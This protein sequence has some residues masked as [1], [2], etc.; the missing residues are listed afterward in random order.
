[1][2][3][4]FLTEWVEAEST[5]GWN[6]FDF[7]KAF[8]G[9][10]YRFSYACA[11]RFLPHGTA[12]WDEAAATGVDALIDASVKLATA[13]KGLSAPQSWSFIKQSIEWEIKKFVSRKR[14][15]ES[16]DAL[17]PDATTD[18]DKFDQ[19]WVRT[20]VALSQ[21]PSFLLE[22]IVDELSKL[23][24]RHQAA[25]ALRYF[26]EFP[27]ARVDELFEVHTATI[28]QLAVRTLTHLVGHHVASAPT[29]PFRPA[30]VKP[31][32]PSP[33][34]VRW[35]ASK[36]GTNLETYLE[37]VRVN[38][39]EDVSYIVGMIRSAHGHQWVP[40]QREVKVCPS[41]P[42]IDLMTGERCPECKRERNRAAR[43]ARSERERRAL[44]V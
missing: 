30:P 11:S 24:I 40:T 4:W 14:G 9:Q 39:R 19:S 36:Y 43:P 41:H 12:R 17:E 22:G 27:V 33:R 3:D 15:L 28:V 1:M 2:T 44:V 10:A 26:E 34:L 42:D 32:T 25:L 29:I 20:Q 5:K 38:Y 13:D 31:F 21:P 7:M 37:W 35:V 18:T 8:Y 16:I 6:Q 23:P